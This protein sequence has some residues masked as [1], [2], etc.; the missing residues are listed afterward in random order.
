MIKSSHQNQL[1]L[2]LASGLTVV[3]FSSIIVG[4]PITIAYVQVNNVCDHV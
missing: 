1:L 3:V 2:M 4:K